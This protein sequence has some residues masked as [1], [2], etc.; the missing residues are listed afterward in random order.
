MTDVHDPTWDLLA[1]CAGWEHHQFADGPLSHLLMHMVTDPA[2]LLRGDDC[3]VARA[4]VRLVLRDGPTFALVASA[5]LMRMLHVLQLA[6]AT[7]AGRYYDESVF[8]ALD[9]AL[10]SALL[11]AGMEK[12]KVVLVH[13]ATLLPR[14]LLPPGQIGGMVLH[15]ANAARREQGAAALA[16]CPS[17]W[18]G[19]LGQACA[20][21]DKAVLA[22]VAA[23]DPYALAYR[24]SAREVHGIALDRLAVY[25]FAVGARDQ[26]RNR[27]QALQALPWLLPLMTAQDGCGKR[28]GVRLICRAIDDGLSLHDAV[29]QAFGVPR[30][31]V[32][33]LG[34]R[35]LPA[36]WRFDVQ[37]LQRLL[38]LLAWLPPERRPRSILQFEALTALG[39]A[40]AAPFAYRGR[41]ED[42][43]ALARIAGCMRQWLGRATQGRTDDT[44][45]NAGIVR[46]AR[47]LKDARDFLR[48]LFDAAR[49][50][51]GL[52]VDAA[53]AW[54]LRWCASI[55]M[56]RMLAL[57]QAWH[58]AVTG[59][60]HD[61]TDGSDSSGTRWPA[62]LATPWHGKHRT[63]IELTSRDALHIE[64]Q[65]MGHC[66]GSYEAVCRSGNSVIVSLR[67]AAGVP[68]STA[69]LQLS[70][71]VPAIQ[72]AQH[73]AAHN[74]L[75]DADCVQALAALLRDLNRAD[76]GPVLRRRAF[77][78]RQREK[79]SRQDGGAGCEGFTFSVAAQLAA[80][81]LATPPVAGS[82]TLA[83][84][85]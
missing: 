62:V 7:L 76:Q 56:T 33:W 1:Q 54:V 39:S 36:N 37:R 75:P 29:A 77:Q 41:A 85:E 84:C 42:P 15:A 16:A 14:P 83:L 31:V 44:L 32:R 8:S 13:N 67:T 11:T 4:S 5:P 80:R 55:G 69:Q 23:L 25:N 45:T 38:V 58:V 52:D 82:A 48:A 9:A 3:G 49:A 65:K 57:S 34:R 17:K 24:A 12:A 27:T 66:V 50:I 35:A 40:L 21:D 6:G 68:M 20:I 72:A 10:A 71:A 19:Q 26:S 2:G 61:D 51:D 70:D 46:R 60:Q 18:F 43:V 47:E 63:A 79:Q 22:F 59:A 53:D 73:R 81:R 78:R 64:G 30:E 74:A 28:E